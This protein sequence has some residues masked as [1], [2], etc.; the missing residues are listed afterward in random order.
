MLVELSVPLGLDYGPPF[1]SLPGDPCGSLW[2]PAGLE[3]GGKAV[4]LA[5]SDPQEQCLV[6]DLHFPKHAGKAVW[7]E[8]GLLG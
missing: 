2:I 8:E 3:S 7:P 5:P 4:P 1:A 6:E